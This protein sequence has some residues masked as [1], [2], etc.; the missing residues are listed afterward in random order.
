[1]R[2]LYDLVAGLG[3]WAPG[4]TDVFPNM[5]QVSRVRPGGGTGRLTWRKVHGGR[6]G[7]FW[8]GQGPSQR[9]Y[10]EF[11]TRVRVGSPLTAEQAVG[12]IARHRATLRRKRGT[13]LVQVRMEDGGGVD[14]RGRDREQGY[15]VSIC[16]TTQQ[17]AEVTNQFSPP[18]FPSSLR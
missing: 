14:L 12:T 15:L 5:L 3:L 2:V 11:G 10:D 8:L 1:M 18:G 9:C 6:F 4:V 7:P 16:H 17:V 13:L